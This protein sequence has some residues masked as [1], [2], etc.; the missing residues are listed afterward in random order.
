MLKY[1]VSNSLLSPVG[2]NFPLQMTYLNYFGAEVSDSSASALVKGNARAVLI[3]NMH[4]FVC[5]HREIMHM[6]PISQ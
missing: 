4:V 3:P 6:A 2:K 5:K 1:Y